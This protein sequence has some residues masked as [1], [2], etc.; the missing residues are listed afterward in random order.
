MSINNTQFLSQLI[1]QFVRASQQEQTSRYAQVDLA[2]RIYD[3]YGYQGL[4]E[5][6]RE[7]GLDVRRLTEYARIGESFPA[8][9]RSKYPTLLYTHYLMAVRN[10]RYYTEG[11]GADPV[12]WAEQ[13]F[14][15]GWSTKELRRQGRESLV[16]SEDGAAPVEDVVRRA[17]RM[18][19]KGQQEEAQIEA[20]LLRY[21][22]TFS[23][24]TG[25]VLTLCR[26]AYVAP[27]A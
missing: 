19:M 11:K 25:V 18:V 14:L 7:S 2:A 3:L 27:S 6:A 9:I 4:H 16:I 8:T 5:L 1:R 24:V 13:A 10:S 21:N 15:S 17:V 22:A 23:A 26:A 20:A 12:W